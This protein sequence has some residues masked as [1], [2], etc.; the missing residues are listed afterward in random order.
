M[1]STAKK[2]PPLACLFFFWFG[3][4]MET[5][6]RVQKS[7]NTIKL[8]I[9]VMICLLLTYCAHR[10]YSAWDNN[11]SPVSV[12]LK[13]SESPTPERADVP[14]LANKETISSSDISHTISKSLNKDVSRQEKRPVTPNPVKV[15][16]LTQAAQNEDSEQR[17]ETFAVSQEVIN[18]TKN[19]LD[20]NR[21]GSP[22][23]ETQAT[24]VGTIAQTVEMHQ[25]V[26]EDNTGGTLAA[27]YT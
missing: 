12:N 14:R 19:L 24:V 10:Q 27:T 25:D 3:I 6:P 23:H 21:P 13:N 11:V 2:V 8:A 17:Q 18:K 7:R 15:K 4:M 5:G 1:R 9:V 16:T 26:P 22:H 20:N